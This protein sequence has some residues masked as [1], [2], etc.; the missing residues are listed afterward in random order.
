MNGLTMSMSMILV[1]AC[2]TY[3]MMMET[4]EDFTAR[5]HESAKRD[6][7]PRVAGELGWLECRGPVLDEYPESVG[8]FDSVRLG[9][10]WED[11]TRWNVRYELQA[12][13]FGFFDFD[14]KSRHHTDGQ[15]DDAGAALGIV[16]SDVK[17]EVARDRQGIWTATFK[18]NASESVF[19][20][21]PMTCTAH[22]R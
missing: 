1:I 3:G 21:A 8:A 6:G 5:A 9:R 10:D 16:A 11:E 19:A 12:A 13:E 15:G 17:I 7:A 14:Q 22:A 20:L 18:P 4:F 2:G